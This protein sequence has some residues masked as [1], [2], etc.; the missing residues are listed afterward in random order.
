MEAI[1]TG[2]RCRQGLP[3]SSASNF[4]AQSGFTHDHPF[5]FVPALSSEITTPQP[6]ARSAWM[7]LQRCSVPVATILTRSTCDDG[8]IPG[9][10]ELRIRTLLDVPRQSS[11][12][13]HH[14]SHGKGHNP[15]TYGPEVFAGTLLPTG[16]FSGNNR[17]GAIRAH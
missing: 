1:N 10:P 12:G 14:I 8:E 4:A 7:A 11:L 16:S 5:G 17:R 9:D 15:A 3:A 13:I 6:K 2:R